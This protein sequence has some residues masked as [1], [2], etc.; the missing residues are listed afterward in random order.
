MGTDELCS[1][2]MPAYTLHLLGLVRRLHAERGLDTAPFMIPQNNQAFLVA[3]QDLQNQKNTP[4]EQTITNL[5]VEGC[6]Q[7]PM[8]ASW[9]LMYLTFITSMGEYTS[10]T[11]RFQ[12]LNKSLQHAIFSQ[13]NQNV[14]Q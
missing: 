13:P 14:L 12:T 5:T 9:K 4:S 10:G 2:G 3:N 1:V 6:S 7:R 11:F 8:W